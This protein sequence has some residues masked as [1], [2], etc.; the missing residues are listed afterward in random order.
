MDDESLP[1]ISPSS[2]QHGTFTQP[3]KWYKILLPFFVFAGIVF[4][5]TLIFIL[6]SSPTPPPEPE[7]QPNKIAFPVSGI[8]MGQYKE[9]A[10]A[11]DNLQCSEIGNDM[12][13]KGGSAVDAAIAA[14]LCN[15]IVNMYHSGIGGGTVAVVFDKENDKFYH[16][17]G[18][19]RAPLETDVD[20]FE[21][22]STSGS[23]SDIPECLRGSKSILI[24][25]EVSTFQK[26]HEKMGKLEWQEL[27]LP[28]VDLC[29]SGFYVNE[30][31]RE[32]IDQFIGVDDGSSQ[33]DALREYFTNPMTGTWYQVGE[34]KKC[35]KLAETLR[36]IAVNPDDFYRGELAND[37]VQDLVDI[38]SWATV[39]DFNTFEA[40]VDEEPFRMDMEDMSFF[41]SKPPSGG[42]V[43]P[44]TLNILRSY[45][46]DTKASQEIVTYHRMLEAQKFA[47]GEMIHF[48]DP[49]FMDEEAEN[50]LKEKLSQMASLDYGDLLRS[51]IN[52]S[53]ILPPEV[54]GLKE[55]HDS[56]TN[57]LQST[58]HI[59]VLDSS[60][61]A[62]A[63]TTTVSSTY[64]QIFNF[65]MIDFFNTF[66]FTFQLFRF[67]SMV[68]GGRSGILFNNGMNNF[69]I[70][71]SSVES[72]NYLE[73]GKQ[74]MNSLSPTIVIDKNNQ[75]HP[76]KL[77]VGA[78]GG[79]Y[80]PSAVSYV[81]A[82]HLW[83]GETLKQSIDAARTFDDSVMFQYEPQWQQWVLDDLALRGHV[84]Q[85]KFYNSHPSV[86]QA[87]RRY[88]NNSI[89][90]MS[91]PRIKGTGTAGF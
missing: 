56:K 59:S 64:E 23:C 51:K 50:A 18:Y 35:P 67:G 26:M 12:L 38:D 69:Y 61:N 40:M 62:V 71:S 80:I 44:F 2:Y 58:S 84:N 77:I 27:V 36:K 33:Y 45:Q 1:I 55:Y 19:G 25:G 73:P 28:S 49:F 66:F 70:N 63:L 46:F 43:V 57:F 4:L 10:V 47:F 52:D 79:S 30:P 86:C 20:Y 15:G 16:F 7:P 65:D 87:I 75:E 31:F 14:M 29:D 76:V 5:I 17:N 22:K 91:D 60:G 72:I 42:S 81:I 74:P 90:A 8:Q 3:Q 88:D 54:Y 24:P 53:G 32:G 37:I 83:F 78:A 82:R 39:E 34:V 11:C 41:T 48:G 68:M 13:L 89:F 9:A 21:E 6:V 85:G